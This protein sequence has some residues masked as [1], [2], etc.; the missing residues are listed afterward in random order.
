M[1]HTPETHNVSVSKH[2]K[3][4]KNG[5]WMCPPT[6]KLDFTHP[7]KRIDYISPPQSTQAIL[8]VAESAPTTKML[9]K[10]S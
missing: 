4:K 5:V 2:L 9:K 7:S 6:W 10:K 1:Y 3:G 8:R